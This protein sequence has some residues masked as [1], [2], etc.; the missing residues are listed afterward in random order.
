MA[1]LTPAATLRAAATVL[2]CDHLHPVQPPE[3]SLA[4]PGDCRMCGAPFNPEF[5]NG[6]ERVAVPLAA[7]LEGSAED[8]GGA[9]EYLARTA[10]PE[11]VFD[12]FDYVDE[13]ESVRAALDIARSILG[14]TS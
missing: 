8:L 5:V 13:P 12:P 2:R 9:E 6:I 11:E 14:R 10:P 7:W 4:K 3:G 1:D